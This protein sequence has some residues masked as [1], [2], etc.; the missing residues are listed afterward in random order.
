VRSS[1]VSLELEP[2]PRVARSR[3]PPHR[4]ALPRC[5]PSPS[6]P[7]RPHCPRWLR[8]PARH[9]PV[10]S[11]LKIDPQA[12]NR[13]MPARPLPSAAVRRRPHTCVRSQPLDQDLTI[14]INPLLPLEL[15]PPPAVRSRSNG[16]D[17]VSPG[18][19][20]SNRQDLTFL[21]KT[22]LNFSNFT[23]MPFCSS[24]FFTVT[25]FCYV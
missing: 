9:L 11:A 14:L 22:P 2:V 23:K 7:G 16:S 10:Q 15:A 18:L 20:Q 24:R 17:R 8:R 21:Q 4:S 25:S 3:S 19:Y 1:L 6:R 5:V 12:R 13:G